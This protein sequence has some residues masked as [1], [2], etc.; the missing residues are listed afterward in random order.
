MIDRLD[1]LLKLYMNGAT[2]TPEEVK[3]LDQLQLERLYKEAEKAHSEDSR[4]RLRGL[5]WKTHTE[6]SRIKN[7]TVRLEKA[8]IL[9]MKSL[10]ELQEKLNEVSGKG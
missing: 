3:E 4:R 8:G 2:L 1:E 7:P 5:V 6:L 9:M 10:G